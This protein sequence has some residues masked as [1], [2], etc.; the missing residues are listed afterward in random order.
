MLSKPPLW[1]CRR[2]SSRASETPITSD[3]TRPLTAAYWQDSW[4]IFPN[5]TLNYGLR[6]ELDQQYAPLSTDK[7][8]FAPRVSIAW[9]PFKDHKTAVRA[10]YGLFYGPIDSQIPSVDYSL[11]VLNANNTSVENTGPGNQVANATAGCGIAGIIPAQGQSPCNRPISIYVDPIT[12]TG[13]PLQNSAVVFQTLFAEGLIQCTKP[14]P[15]STACITPAALSALGIPHGE[16]RAAV[17]AASA[18]HQPARLPES[19]GPTGQLWN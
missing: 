12:P 5:L 10:G 11:G 13:L 2:F 9:D 6:Y 15:G 3:V 18:V 19:A 4:S 16:F 1:D 7:D 8:N 17:A 14:G